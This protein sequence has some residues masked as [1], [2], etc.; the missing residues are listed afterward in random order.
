MR[1]TW[2]I[3]VQAADDGTPPVAVRVR[4][5]LKRMLRSHRLRCVDFRVVEAAERGKRRRKV[6]A[7]KEL[8]EL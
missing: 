8:K 4:M 5:L 1:E 6:A 2:L 3:T 7:G